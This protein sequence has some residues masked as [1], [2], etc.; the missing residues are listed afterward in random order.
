MCGVGAF[1]G[2]SENE[3]EERVRFLIIKHDFSVAHFL[4]FVKP[5][6]EIISPLRFFLPEKHRLKG[7]LNNLR[8]QRV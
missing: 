4:P 3:R 8:S 2:K 5:P 1:C 7:F 6:Q